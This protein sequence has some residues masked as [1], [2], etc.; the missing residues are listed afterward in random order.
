MAVIGVQHAVASPI[1]KYNDS[2]MPTY[3]EGFIVSRLTK[4]DDNL[5][6]N[7]NS[8]YSDNAIEETDKSFSKGTITFGTYGLGKTI[9]ER[10]QVRAKL[11]GETV[12]EEEL[13]TG[14][15]DISQH[16]G[17]GYIKTERSSNVDYYIARWYFDTQFA[18]PSESVETKGESINFQTQDV[19]GTI[20]KID[21]WGKDNIKKEKIFDTYKEAETWLD[22]IANLKAASE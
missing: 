10:Y 6:Y 7:D 8:A 21:N 16:V 13:I 22:T 11:F 1:T 3:G 9:K 2:A 17:F 14:A 4:I 19:E 18:P 20:Y 15:N 12:S 5:E